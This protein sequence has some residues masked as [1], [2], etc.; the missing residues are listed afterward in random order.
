MASARPAAALLSI[1]HMPSDPP[2]LDRR[3]F[4]GVAGGAALI[5]TVGGKQVTVRDAA[6]V[7]EADAAAASIPRPRAAA[8]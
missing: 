5:C 8:Q 6:D 3:D 4:L 1:P 7:T 2:R